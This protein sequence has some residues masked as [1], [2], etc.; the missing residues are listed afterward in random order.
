M[1]NT[2]TTLASVYFIAVTFYD[3]SQLQFSSE[4][5]VDIKL[6]RVSSLTASEGS[7]VCAHTTSVQAFVTTL[8]WWGCRLIFKGLFSL[9][10]YLCIC[11]NV[12]MCTFMRM[13]QEAKR[14]HQIS[15]SNSERWVSYPECMLGARLWCS[16]GAARTRSHLSSAAF[17]FF[18]V[19]LHTDFKL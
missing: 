3:L 19:A 16:G 8:V 2:D 12:F 7:S 11:L 10:F 14:G 13:P 9:L 6:G 15:W 5:A 17:Q 4:G 18:N 1:L